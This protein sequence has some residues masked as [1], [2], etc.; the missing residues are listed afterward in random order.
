M[1]NSFL[2][3]SAFLILI[4]LGAMLENYD[5]FTLAKN[6][7][8]NRDLPSP[9]L[10]Y[11]KRGQI[12]KELGLR[13]VVPMDEGNIETD[14][15]TKR[16]RISNS[17][18][19]IK[20]NWIIP[21]N[22]PYNQIPSSM[23]LDRKITGTGIPILSLVIEND[24]LYNEKTGLIPNALKK[25]REWERPCFITF[26]EYGKIQFASGAGLRVHGGSSRKHE[27][28]SWRLYFRSMY[29]DDAVESKFLL[30]YERR[31]ITSIVL[32]KEK[33]RGIHFL[34]PLSYDIASR[35]GCIVPHC[36]PVMLYF[37]GKQYSD[38][39][40]HFVEHLN[41][42]F[43]RNLLGHNNFIFVRTE[44]RVLSEKLKKSRPSE[45][46][47]F[48]SWC[49]DSSEKMTVAQLSR[50]VDVD[51]FLNWWIA[52]LFM[53]NFDPYQ[54]LAVFNNDPTVKKWFW[55]MYDMDECIQG[56]L[57]YKGKI[58]EQTRVFDELLAGTHY[59]IL[60]DPRAILFRRLLKEDLDFLKFFKQRL[61]DVL[62]KTMGNDFF[63]ERI[64]LYKTTARN[65]G[66]NDMSGLEKAEIF[67]V[68]R[69]Q[70]VLYLV[71]RY[72]GQIHNQAMQ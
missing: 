22:I 29:G 30:N 34:N 50:R 64:K 61:N 19:D 4:V 7:L 58:W 17:K 59:N 42:D 63:A 47:D 9:L 46:L 31:P 38:D 6:T 16:V 67:L 28:K 15:F 23:V 8:R 53:A 35:I 27:I 72:F 12:M 65:F 43:I 54:G 20:K 40:Y 32:R 51:N 33:G 52:V 41:K 55:I 69:P 39:K 25:G 2:I 48:I 24:Y 3:I 60:N 26:Y 71:D 21:E 62:T 44:K 13:Y 56:P 70:Y 49:R 68:N 10:N 66:F 18:L 1:K 37:N 11:G 36:K 57:N 14:D 5:S 45:Y